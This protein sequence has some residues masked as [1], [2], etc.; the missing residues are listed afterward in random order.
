MTIKPMLQAFKMRLKHIF[1]KKDKSVAAWPPTPVP[2]LDELIPEITRTQLGHMKWSPA[3]PASGSHDA[4]IELYS[5]NPQLP[6]SVVDPI[7]ASVVHGMSYHFGGGISEKRVK[8][9]MNMSGPE[10]ETPKLATIRFVKQSCATPTSPTMPLSWPVSLDDFLTSL[11]DSPAG[12]LLR[13]CRDADQHQLGLWM[14]QRI[15]MDAGIVHETSP[16]SSQVKDMLDYLA[17]DIK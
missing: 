12:V 8:A 3:Y 4:H 1:A 2:T 16:W 13:R 10:V 15:L 9:L 5:E 14:V 11:R 17:K 6:D 7:I